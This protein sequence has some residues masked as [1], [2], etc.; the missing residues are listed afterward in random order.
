MFTSRWNFRYFLYCVQKLYTPGLLTPL[1]NTYHTKIT[2]IFVVKAPILFVVSEDHDLSSMSTDT[3]AYFPC[4]YISIFNPWAHSPLVSNS[5]SFA[6]YSCLGVFRSSFLFLFHCISFVFFT[7]EVSA[8]CTL[9]LD[10]LFLIRRWVPDLGLALVSTNLWSQGGVWVRNCAWSR[11]L[12]PDFCPSRG[13]N[14]GLLTWQSSTQ[15]IDHRVHHLFS[16]VS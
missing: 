14:L 15:Q 4:I 3:A 10:P 13:L 11:N 1:T 16:S 8:F 9:S 2:F 6:F 5:S 12:D 7:T